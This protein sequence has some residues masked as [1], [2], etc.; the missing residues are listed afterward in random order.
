MVMTIIVAFVTI[1]GVIAISG[2]IV[3]RYRAQQTYEE[4]ER[5]DYPL[6][7]TR[8]PK[9]T[10]KMSINESLDARHEFQRE[11]II[12][13]SLASRTSSAE[14][15][16]DNFNNA[17]DA[18]QA[19]INESPYCEGYEIENQN[20]KQNALMDDWKEFE[21][22][23][24]RDNSRSL[25]RH[26]SL[27]RVL[28]HPPLARRNS[29]KPRTNS[30]PL[31]RTEEEI[32][33]EGKQGPNHEGG[34]GTDDKEVKSVEKDDTACEEGDGKSDDCNDAQRRETMGRRKSTASKA[35]VRKRKRVILRKQRGRS[36]SA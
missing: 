33:E 13:K 14:S 1:C 17:N 16:P 32:L 19:R 36:Q 7:S 35:L 23:I 30:R 34:N 28:T 20:E 29:E 31:S 15:R 24:R 4:V 5:I 18:G 2:I 11:Y 27:T 22:G 6:P 25:R 8:L 12:R 26:P 9:R 3:L 10:S 21:A